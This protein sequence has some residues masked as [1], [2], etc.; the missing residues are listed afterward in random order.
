MSQSCST[1]ASEDLG[2][3]IQRWE[4]DKFWKM[5]IYTDEKREFFMMSSAS[6]FAGF[7]LE[8]SG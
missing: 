6:L 4:A 1:R 5:V 3:R 8:I 7:L 2:R